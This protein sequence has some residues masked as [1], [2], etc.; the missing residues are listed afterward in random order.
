ML[1][2]AAN[3]PIAER[4]SAPN[5]MLAIVAIH[6]AV[7]AAVMSAKM[8]LPARIGHGPLVVDFIPEDDPPPLRVIPPDTPLPPR[9]STLDLPPREVPLPSNDAPA[10]DSSPALPDL[11]PIIGPDPSPPV[12]ADPAPAPPVKIGARLL[13]PSSELRPPYPASKLLAGEEAVLRLRL[14][15]DE[16]GRVVA[17]EPLGLADRAFVDA[18][19]RHLLAHWRYRPASEDGRAVASSTVITLRFELEG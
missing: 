6:V 17:V 15:I 18:A 1:A 13:T 11:G 10:V 4:R 7:I 5:A 3:R 14:T 12:Q 2:Y 8:D 19:R 16:R 9:Q